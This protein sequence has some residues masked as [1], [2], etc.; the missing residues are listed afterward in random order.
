M[1]GGALQE[2]AIT[3]TGGGASEY[4]E[5]VSGARPRSCVATQGGRQDACNRMNE[6]L[7]KRQAE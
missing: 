1:G 2:A 3:P 5:L 4:N 6:T 7:L